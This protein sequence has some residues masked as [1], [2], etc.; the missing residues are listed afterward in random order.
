LILTLAF[1]AKDNIEH[2]AVQPIFS[3]PAWQ[4]KTHSATLAAEDAN[5]PTNQQ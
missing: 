1:A 5:E 4:G 2:A 3:R